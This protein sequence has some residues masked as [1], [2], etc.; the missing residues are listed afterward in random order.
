M[1]P[2][3]LLAPCQQRSG[4]TQCASPVS[5]IRQPQAAASH[6]PPSIHAAHTS[7]KRE[8]LRRSRPGT[9]WAQQL[10][11]L[12][13]PRYVIYIPDIPGAPGAPQA[14]LAKRH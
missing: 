1:L 7:R 10:S 9:G 13:R 3:Y 12:T 4:D 6:Q 11:I 5:P 8:A 14:I 2:S